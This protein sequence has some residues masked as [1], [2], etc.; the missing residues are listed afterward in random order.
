MSNG[1]GRGRRIA[2]FVRHG[3]FD[4][5]PNTASAH[6]PRALSQKGQAQAEAA[7]GPIAALCREHGLMIDK[8]IEASQLLRAWQTANVLASA[9]EAETGRSHHVIQRDELIERGL[10]SAANLPLDEIAEMLAK[11]P[12]IGPLPEGWRRRPEFRLPLPGAESLMQAGARVASRVA[13][14]LDS[15]PDDDPTD[16]ARLFVAHSGCLRH[17]SVVLG[18]VDVRDVSGLS[19]D[20]LGCVLVEKKPSGEWVHLAG[21]FAK[22]RVGR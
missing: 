11:D 22:H 19:M 18:A 4:R 2:A 17:A 10:G 3:D 21:D 5:P 9:L 20:F 16:L 14:S 7:A 13:A 8:R 6:S 1:T 12:R 15:I